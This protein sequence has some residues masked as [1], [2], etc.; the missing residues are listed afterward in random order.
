[1]K[2]Q[3]NKSVTKCFIAFHANKIRIFM[4]TE[5]SFISACQLNFVDTISNTKKSFIINAQLDILFISFE[6]RFETYS[7]IFK[8]CTSQSSSGFTKTFTLRQKRFGFLK[9]EKKRKQIV[10]VSPNSKNYFP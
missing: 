9:R 7:R 10:A 5:H 4:S 8:I 2:F 1:M 3:W 6:M